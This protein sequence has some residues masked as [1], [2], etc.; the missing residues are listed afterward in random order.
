MT[1]G[2]EFSIG[3]YY[4]VYNRGNN[5]SKIFLNSRDQERF[6]T[7][8]Y[9]CNGTKSLHYFDIPDGA[10]YIIERGG[11]LVDIGAYCVMYNHFHLLLKE[12][13]IKGISRFM[14]KVSTAYAMYFNTRY[15]RTGTPFEGTYKG[16]HANSDEYLKYLFAYIHLNPAEHKFPDWKEG[17]QMITSEAMNYVRSYRHSSLRATLDSNLPENRILNNAAFP[18]YFKNN[19]ENLEEI[20]GWLEYN[21][22]V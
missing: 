16:K 9:L 18:G 15:D 5:K 17:G 22:E 6:K 1:R 20:A 14:Q 2:F 7:L 10:E 4:H 13:T 19:H 3:E 21:H 11:Q 8:L 12:K